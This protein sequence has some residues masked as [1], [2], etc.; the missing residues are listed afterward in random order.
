MAPADPRVN[1]LKLAGD[2]RTGHGRPSL[3]WRRALSAVV[4]KTHGKVLIV[5]PDE[6]AAQALRIR[7]STEYKVR[8]CTY[9]ELSEDAHYHP[10]GREMFQVP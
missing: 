5:L 9:A 4:S 10:M 2:D 8:I 7:L 1:D 3:L 6:A